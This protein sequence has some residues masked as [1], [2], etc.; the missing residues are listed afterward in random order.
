M[1]VW[2]TWS[3]NT[4]MTRA[5]TSR[6][7]RVR[8][9]NMVM[10]I[11]DTASFGL[12]RSRTLA[13]VSVSSASPRSEKNAHSIGMTTPSEQASAFTVNSPSDGWQSMST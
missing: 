9:S 4:S 1:T 13:T 10:T 3:P 6:A 5:I 7:C 11:P 12:S 8:A 2:K